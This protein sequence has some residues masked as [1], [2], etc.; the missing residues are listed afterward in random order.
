MIEAEDSIYTLLIFLKK[1]NKTH[2]REKLG[3]NIT[4]HQF[5][6]IKESLKCAA[7]KAS[8]IPGNFYKALLTLNRSY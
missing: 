7:H 1:K 4:E 5:P 6:K 8:H 2:D 3:E